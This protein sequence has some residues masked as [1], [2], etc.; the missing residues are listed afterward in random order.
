MERVSR[1]MPGGG[2]PKLAVEDLHVGFGHGAHRVAAVK[3]VSFQLA[4]NES[5]GIVGE[6]GSG[7]STVLRAI[8][9]LAPAENGKILLDGEPVP[10]PRGR[11]FA[12]RV[13]MEFRSE[14]RR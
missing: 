12:R 13:Q 5:F 11:A 4:A 8:C 6:S 14:E 2:A 10:T 7:K 9:G 3:G 1:A